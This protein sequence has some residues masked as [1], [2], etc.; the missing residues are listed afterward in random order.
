MTEMTM[1]LDWMYSTLAGDTTLQGYAPG[2]VWRSEVPVGVD[3]DPTPT[4]FVMIT[5][6][7]RQSRDEIVFGGAR[8]YSELYFEVVIVGHVDDWQTL[9]NGATRIDQLLT[10]GRQ[11][12]ITGG[13]I[14]AGYR[15]QPIEEDPLIAGEI[16]TNTGG[17]YK[18]MAKAA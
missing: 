10:I 1:V 11:T 12:P 17:L 6:Q 14:S 13:T 5:Y 8:A 2:G 16:Q 7:P 18:F 15:V 4:P 3:N 9:S